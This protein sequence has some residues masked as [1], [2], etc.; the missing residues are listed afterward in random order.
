MKYSFSKLDFLAL[1]SSKISKLAIRNI[2]KIIM[3]RISVLVLIIL[4]GKINSFGQTKTSESSNLGKEKVMASTALGKDT[5]PDE[6]KIYQMALS[7][8]DY[9]VAKNAM[10]S[11]IAKNPSR[12]DY[13]DSLARIYFSMNAYPQALAAAEIVLKNQPDNMQMLELTAI[14]QGAMKNEKE[15]LASYEK[16][17]AKSKSIYHLYQIAVLQYSLQRY[18]ECGTSV[19]TIIADKNSATEKIQISV[20]EQNTQ[21]VPLLAAAYNL[22]G[23]LAKELKENDKAKEFFNEALKAYPDFQLAKNNL[24]MM[25]KPAE[26][27]KEKSKKK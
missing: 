24:E 1:C 5:I 17:Y 18:G 16:L 20:D 6:V 22:R 3:K 25:N 21:N 15:A 9:E 23:V 7:F 13:L 26:D 19:E 8:S 4:L 10:F 27:S 12:I 2:N 11:L 14:C